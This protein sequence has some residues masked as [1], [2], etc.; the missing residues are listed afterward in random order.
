MRRYGPLVV[1]ARDPAS[2]RIEL[3]GQVRLEV[4][5]RRRE[6]E[7]PGRLGRVLLGYLTLQRGRA[8]TRDE[9]VEALWPYGPPGD[10][11]RT[12]S[13]LLSALRRVLGPDVV[14][15][16]SELRL[17]L[18]ADAWVDVEWAVAEAALEVLDRPLLQGFDAPWLQERRLE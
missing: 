4:D 5:G 7:L 12:L 18:P 8:V 2:V 6:R 13:T 3:C 16:R 9:L 17:D 14:R 10:P 1:S 15:G 11:G